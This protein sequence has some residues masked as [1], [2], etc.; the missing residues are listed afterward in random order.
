VCFL[1]LDPE[2]E[3]GPSISSSV[4]LCSFV[5]LVYILVLVLVVCLCP[6]SVHVVAT[7][8]GTVLFLLLCSVLPFFCL[9][10]WFFSLYSFVIPSKCLKNVICVA[11]KRC[12]SLLQYPSFFNSFR[13]LFKS[14]SFRDHCC[15]RRTCVSA[16]ICGI[17]K[18][19]TDDVREGMLGLRS[20]RVRVYTFTQSCHKFCSKSVVT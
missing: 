20:Y 7:F 18:K 8:S 5:L 2:D 3:V 1:F 11:S 14:D 17:I 9:I 13:I 19:K 16:R 15:W 4:D 12:S 6:S 10:H